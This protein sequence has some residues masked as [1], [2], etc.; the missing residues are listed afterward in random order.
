MR[1]SRT[2][3]PLLNLAAGQVKITCP[4]CR[5]DYNFAH[6]DAGVYNHN[7]PDA[8]DRVHFLNGYALAGVAAYL[9]SNK[10]PRK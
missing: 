8:C 1:L 5:I 10:P 9:A 7:C 2:E 6:A 4:F 3:A